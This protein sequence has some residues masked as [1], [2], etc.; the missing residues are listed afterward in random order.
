MVKVSESGFSGLKDEQDIYPVKL[1]IK[2]I[3]IQIIFV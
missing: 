2:Q 1:Q 3:Q